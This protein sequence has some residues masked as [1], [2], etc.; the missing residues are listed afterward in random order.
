MDIGEE[1]RTFAEL[2]DRAT[3]KK[4]ALSKRL[5]TGWRFDAWQKTLVET[6]DGGDQ[7]VYVLGWSGKRVFGQLKKMDAVEASKHARDHLD[8]VFSAR[9]RLTTSDPTGNSDSSIRLF[10][11]VRIAQISG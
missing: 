3:I 9:E 10:L 6:A 8:G 5:K 11:A 7:E 2:V 1:P 4:S